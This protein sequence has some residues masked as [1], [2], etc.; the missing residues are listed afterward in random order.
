M[1]PKV[2]GLSA[3][4]AAVLGSAIAGCGSDGSA[5]TASQSASVPSTPVAVETVESGTVTP[6][7][8][9]A[10]ALAASVSYADAE[11][12]FRRGRYA[13]A[14]GLFSSYIASHPDNPWGHYMYGLSAWKSGEHEQAMEGFDEALRLDPNHRKSML[15]SA[16]VLLETSRPREALERIERALSIEPLSSEGLRLL[17]RARYELDQVPEAIEAYQRAITLD[18]RDVWAMNN[19]ALIY[20]QQDRSA[21]ALPALARAVQLRSNAPVFQNNLGMAL[22]RSG[23]ITAARQA[24]AAALKADSTYAKASAS[25]TRLGGPVV[26]TAVDSTQTVDIIVLAREFQTQIEQWRDTTAVQS[27]S[28][29]VDPMTRDTA[30]QE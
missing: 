5:K 30:T 29:V 2:S 11:T 25:L 16:R 26:D 18:D 14:T 20:L 3:I 27:D 9:D 21:D 12:A 19:L 24:Y 1:S 28:V 4:A 22:E 15:N 6:P 10:A 23:H 7:V 8:V 17:G 13:E